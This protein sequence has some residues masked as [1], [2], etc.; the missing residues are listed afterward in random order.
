MK[1][2]IDTSSLMKKYIVEEGSSEFDVFLEKV[3]EI[4]V[5]PTCRLEL[6][7]VLQRRLQEKTLLKQQ[8]SSILAEVER[9][10]DY[11]SQVLWNEKLEQEAVV[12]IQKYH[13]KTLDSLQLAAACLAK[14]DVF[15]TSDKKLFAA[16]GKEIKNVQFF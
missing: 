9:D 6:H 16:A 1:A 8:V 13:L 2:F 12:K 3:S 14:A 7:S 15:M 11:F 10:F 5:S 4:I